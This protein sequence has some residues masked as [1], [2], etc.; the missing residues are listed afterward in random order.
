MFFSDLM[1]TNFL[2]LGV[3]EWRVGRRK[4]PSISYQELRVVCYLPK[5]TI[6]LGESIHGWL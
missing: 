1:K 2:S 6:V 5:I 3:T 4:W